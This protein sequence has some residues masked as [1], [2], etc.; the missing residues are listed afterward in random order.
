MNT[1][2]NNNNNDGSSDDEDEHDD[3]NKYT[4]QLGKQIL[5][6]GFSH[7]DH[8]NVRNEG[9]AFDII[10]VEAEDGRLHH[11]SDMLVRFKGERDYDFNSII[12]K[13]EPSQETQEE[14]DMGAAAAAWFEIHKKDGNNDPGNPSNEEKSSLVALKSILKPGRNVVSYFL[15]DGNDDKSKVIPIGVARAFMFLWWH[16]DMVVVSDIDGTIT[17]SNARGVLG[18]IVTSQYGKASHDGICHLLTALS[19]KS[20]VAYLTSRPITLANHTRKFLANLKQNE[21]EN[22]T[23]SLP[24]GPLLG[25]GGKMPKVLLM[26]LVSHTTQKFKSKKLHEK[27]VKPFRQAAA[28]S[29][30]NSSPPSMFVAGFGNNLNDMQAYHAIGMD[31]N[32]IYMIDKKSQIVTFG[33]SSSPSDKKSGNGDGDGDF[34]FPPHAWYKERIAGAKF[35]GYTDTKLLDRL[36]LLNADGSKKYLI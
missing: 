9:Y 35:N 8:N 5:D 20:Q 1:N 30:N 12:M 15:F 24:E 29:E 3:Q 34:T 7:F 21:N 27:I 32:S 14:D 26:E 18:T 31:L 23:G 28:G 16:T 25:F 4:Y 10:V 22:N 17:K 2:D 6:Y 13:V 19:H 11:N 33:E 36:G